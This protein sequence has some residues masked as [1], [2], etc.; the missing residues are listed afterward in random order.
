MGARHSMATAEIT[1]S[2]NLEEIVHDDRRKTSEENK[3][4]NRKNSAKEE[5]VSVWVKKSVIEYER[6]LKN[7]QIELLK[8]QNHVKEKGLKVLMIFEGRIKEMR[9]RI[10]TQYG[11]PD[12]SA[13]NMRTLG[14]VIEGKNGK[15]TFKEIIFSTGADIIKV[16]EYDYDFGKIHG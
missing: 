14:I 13:A 6:E 12:V 3:L 5:R 2:D 8:L 9:F 11:L 4:E 10:T 15:D 16:K 1:H 7:L